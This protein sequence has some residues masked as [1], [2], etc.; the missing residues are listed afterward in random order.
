MLLSRKQCMKTKKK[1]PLL[2]FANNLYRTAHSINPFMLLDGA[3]NTVT[4]KCSSQEE[5]WKLYEALVEFFYPKNKVLKETKAKE[6]TWEKATYPL[7]PWQ[8][9]S[10]LR[11]PAM[12]FDG[13]LDDG[14]ECKVCEGSGVVEYIIRK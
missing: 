7:P 13:K 3:T 2:T 12:C 5:G 1:K 10:S 6:P 8:L 9:L 14:T 11:C 4:M